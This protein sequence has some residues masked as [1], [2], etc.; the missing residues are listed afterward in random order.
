M[1]HKLLKELKETDYYDFTWDALWYWEYENESCFDYDY[2]GDDISYETLENGLVDWSEEIP[3][4]VKRQHKID[5][6]IGNIENHS[7]NIAIFWP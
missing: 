3:T 2:Y 5:Q 4:A 1:T 7:N 6:I